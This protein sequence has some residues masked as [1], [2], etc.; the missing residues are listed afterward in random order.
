MGP[1]MIDDDN[2]GTQGLRK[3]SESGI[4]GT[5]FFGEC[6]FSDSMT[7]SK[8]SGSLKLGSTKIGVLKSG[9]LKLGLLKLDPIL[10][11][12]P[13]WDPNFSDPS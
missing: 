5:H 7:S 12:H 8:K 3:K 6:K 13:N 1:R 10:V 9:S 2:W 11:I 4:F